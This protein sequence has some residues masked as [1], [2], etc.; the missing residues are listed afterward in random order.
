MDEATFLEISQDNRLLATRITAVVRKA[1]IKLGESSVTDEAIDEM[2]AKIRDNALTALHLIN[3]ERK[4]VIYAMNWLILSFARVPDHWGTPEID[5]DLLPLPEEILAMKPPEHFTKVRA[6]LIARNVWIPIEDICRERHIPDAA[7]DRLCK[8]VR[9]A[10]LTIVYLYRILGFKV[11]EIEYIWE[12]IIPS[13]ITPDCKGGGTDHNLRNG[14]ENT[15]MRCTRYRGRVQK[16]TKYLID[17]DA[18]PDDFRNRFFLMSPDCSS[19]KRGKADK[20]A[21]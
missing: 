8:T 7:I 21:F 1:I 2:T 20:D 9:D 15:S 6:W 18:K 17:H 3:L 19:G 11:R 13:W 4:N 12:E 10:V 5:T 16:D 14:E